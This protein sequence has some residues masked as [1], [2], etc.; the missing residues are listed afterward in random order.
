VL[1]D[2]ESGRV[3]GGIPAIDL[4]TWKRVQAAQR[5]LPGMRAELRALRARIEAIEKERGKA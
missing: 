4:P 1:A 2:V 5:G 3:V